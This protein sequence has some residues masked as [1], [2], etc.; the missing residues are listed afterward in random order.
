MIKKQWRNFLWRWHRRLGLS[1]IVIVMWLSA[2]GIM[3]NHTDFF[4]FA[5]KPVYQ[6][7]LLKIYGIK[8]PFVSSYLFTN[9]WFSH[10]GEHLYYNG[11]KLT[12]CQMPFSGMALISEQEHIVAVACA[13]EI[14]LITT[15]GN[16]LERINQNFG[17]PSAINALGACANQHNTVCFGNLA[18]R[19][20]LDVR[21]S[22]WVETTHAI[23]SIAMQTLPETLQQQLDKQLVS[24]NW[25]RVI[26][27]LHSGRLFGLGPWLMDGF[28]LLLIILGFTGLGIWLTTQKRH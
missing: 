17:L 15:D 28:A 19:Y 2:T 26:L 27:D 13:E 18:T 3:L 16:L 12:H 21:T 1:L 10:S 9:Q 14:L 7:L 4:G 23:T 5:N 6:S 22:S 11:N 8:R 20:Q 25:E 24:M